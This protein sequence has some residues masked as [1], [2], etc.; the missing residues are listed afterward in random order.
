[1]ATG[2]PKSRGLGSVCMAQS[3]GAMVG[4]RCGCLSPWG[5]SWPISPFG[6]VPAERAAGALHS[7]WHQYSSAHSNFIVKT[8]TS[9]PRKVSFETYTLFY[10]L[11][12]LGAPLPSE[13]H[14]CGAQ[15]NA[16]EKSFQEGDIAFIIKALEKIFEEISGLR[17]KGR[18]E[19]RLEK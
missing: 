7:L 13:N 14:L 18:L 11:C 15:T 12:V 9:Y 1:M 4:P 8:A 19:M 2:H 5:S 17:V 10:L 3:Y 6:C 16:G